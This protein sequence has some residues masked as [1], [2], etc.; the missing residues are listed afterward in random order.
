MTAFNRPATGEIKP[1][2]EHGELGICRP[3][4]KGRGGPSPRPLGQG[5][6]EFE[7]ETPRGGREGSLP[8]W[9]LAGGAPQ[10]SP[11]S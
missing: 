8:S 2:E 6:P 1:I 5:D 9:A 7:D 10:H 3:R 11:W 4:G